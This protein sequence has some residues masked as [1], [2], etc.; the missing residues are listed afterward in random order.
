MFADHRPDDAIDLVRAWRDEIDRR[1]DLMTAMPG[2]PLGLTREISARYRLPVWLLVIDE[3][4]YHT[5]VAG[6]GAQQKEFYGLLRDGVARGRAAGMGAIVATQRPTHDL[7]PTSLRDL[8]DI[9]IAYRTMT[10]TSSDVILGDDFARR[11]FSGTDIDLTARGVAWLLAENREPIR[12]KTAWIPPEVRAQL[13]VSTVR[14]RP[15]PVDPFPFLNPDD[16]KD[17]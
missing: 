8:F 17:L 2:H 9:R 16:F 14:N 7:I 1:L 4:A 6:T 10:R 11:G 5:T 3:L 12:T 13:S 15:S